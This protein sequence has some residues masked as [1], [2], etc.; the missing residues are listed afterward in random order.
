MKVNDRNITCLL[1]TGSDIFTIDETTWKK[2]GELDAKVTLDD[3]THKMKI[4]V[5]EGKYCKFIRY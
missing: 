1:D 5:I 3:K 2:I 4:F